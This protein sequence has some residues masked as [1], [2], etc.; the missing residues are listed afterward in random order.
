MMKK[1]LSLLIAAGLCSVPALHAFDMNGLA[2]TVQ[3]ASVS[4]QQGHSPLVDALT[5]KLGI[6]PAQAAGGAAALFGDAKSK[7]K[8]ADFSKLTSSVPDI[9][10]LLNNNA[11]SGLTKG[12]SLEKQFASLGLD[13]KMIAQFKPIVLEYVGK[14]AGPQTTQLLSSV[15]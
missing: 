11:L 10:S 1:R 12:L 13:S 5:S 14:L 7:M 4:Q 2:K 6:T 8:P 15:L 9:A 3:G